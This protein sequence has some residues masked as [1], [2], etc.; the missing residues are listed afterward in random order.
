MSVENAAVPSYPL[1]CWRY[2]MLV[3]F[4]C[5]VLMLLLLLLLLL[6]LAIIIFVNVAL[7]LTVLTVLGKKI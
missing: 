6:L 5:L 7:I 1:V 4:S 3:T 2:F